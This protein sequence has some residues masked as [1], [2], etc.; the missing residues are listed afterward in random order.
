[1]TK[2][3]C[4]NMIVKDESHIIEETLNNITSQLDL[5]YWV[6]SDTGSTD[7]TKEIIKSFFEL[8][9]VPNIKQAWYFSCTQLFNP[10]TFIYHLIASSC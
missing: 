6:I 8:Y 9:N 2:T 1:M 7:N 4:L 10:N 5:D 3:I